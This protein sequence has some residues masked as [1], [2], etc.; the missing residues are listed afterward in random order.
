M[1]MANNYFMY[2]AARG[3]GQIVLPWINWVKSV[4]AKWS[5]PYVNTEVMC[6]IAKG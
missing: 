2:I 5:M 3:Q 4:K 6:Q 1:M